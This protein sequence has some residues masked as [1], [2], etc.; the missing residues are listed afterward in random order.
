MRSFL[1]R[2]IQYIAALLLFLLMVLSGIVMNRSG[3]GQIFGSQTAF[4]DEATASLALRTGAAR[5]WYPTEK[6]T[7]VIAADKKRVHE[8]ISG[9]ADL[10]K[11]REKISIATETDYVLA[12]V[13]CSLT[14]SAAGFDKAIRYM[15]TVFH[16]TSPIETS[17]PDIVK[18]AVIILDSRQAAELA[19]K[20]PDIQTIIPA[21]G[22]LSFKQGYIS[23]KPLD[24]EVLNDD[25]SLPENVHELQESEYDAFEWDIFTSYAYYRRIVLKRRYFAPGNVFEFIGIYL[26]FIFVTAAW[27]AWMMLRVTGKC[28]RHI[29]LTV[30]AFQLLWF[31]IRVL[32]YLADR[33]SLLHRLLWYSYYIP[34]LLIPVYL[35]WLT[36]LIDETGDDRRVPGIVRLFFSLS[37]VLCLFVLTNDLHGSVFRISSCNTGNH[38][39][40][41]YGLVFFLIYSYVALMFIFALISMMKNAARVPSKAAKLA[42]LLLMATAGIYTACYS[43]KIQPFADTELTASWNMLISLMLECFI[44]FGLIK[45]N[46]RYVS[47]FIAS[48]INMQILDS[49]NEIVF[50]AKGAGGIDNDMMRFISNNSREKDMLDTGENRLIVSRISGGKVV[51]I[52]DRSGLICLRDEL[53]REKRQLEENNRLL[54]GEEKLKG[55]LSEIKW[56]NMLLDE[57]EDMVT[58]KMMAIYDIAVTLA[59]TDR[60]DSKENVEFRKR[61]LLRIGILTCY[62][63][64]KSNLYLTGQ[65]NTELDIK[66][67]FLSVKESAGIMERYGIQTAVSCDAVSK[68]SM[69]CIMALFDMFEWGAE[70]AAACGFS[71]LF[72]SIAEINDRVRIVLI[73]GNVGRMP[74]SNPALMQEAVE[75]G[76]EIRVNLD[77]TDLLM[78]MEVPHV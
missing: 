4:V 24:I 5:Y 60:E 17:E 31:F 56:R 3:G 9:W 55:E 65:E 11:V 33:H 41:T 48:T 26:L 50:T 1:G 61:I 44:S 68:C 73:I 52:S 20:N 13:Q 49:F 57:I 21:E 70:M 15:D 39:D 37:A 53:E 42:P 58:D 6:V 7:I 59:G 14:G 78:M 72:V 12:A 23:Q 76:A 34:I 67:L 46:T 62:M 10:S 64:R 35:I 2:K 43:L 38:L 16:G 18:Y 69:R 19:A 66:D 22:T 27:G 30:T 28:N 36:L 25:E 45:S 63:K 77:D 51:Y 74:I 8:H 75:T 71:S 32:K 29:Y 54:A 40:Y 47:L